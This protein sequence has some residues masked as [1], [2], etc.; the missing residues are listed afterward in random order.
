MDDTLGL[1][2][3]FDLDHVSAAAYVHTLQRGYFSADA[4]AVDLG[5]SHTDVDRAQ[6][7]LL[8]L[9]LLRPLPADPGRLAP[10]SPNVAVAELVS[11]VERLILRHQEVVD[12]IR[13]QFLALMPTYFEIRRMR[14]QGEA[15]DVV[16]GVDQVRAL[17]RDAAQRC[18][19]EVMTMQP[20][21]ARNPATLS[22]ALPRDL[23]MLA[24]GVRMRVLYQHTAR[25]HLPTQ[26]Y[27][28]AITDAGAE[29]RTTDE[30]VERLIIFDR[31]TAFLPERPQS[32]RVRGAAIV[33]EP[34]IVG[35]LCG[36]FEHTWNSAVPF[37][38][39][40]LPG[41]QT[42]SEDLKQAIVRMLARGE[43]DDVIARR[44]GVS[45]RTC[46]RHIAKIMQDLDATGRF[47]AGVIAARLGMVDLVET[48]K[49]DD[50]EKPDETDSSDE[51]D[52]QDEVDLLD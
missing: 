49:P 21:G 12:R 13:A 31:E 4:I 25:P 6:Q 7:V 35:F 18:T 45:V 17:L 14:N 1:L 15:V 5:L 51:S 39:D 34:A 24:N 19:G 48:E 33:R 3:G 27:V 44:L 2:P 32:G 40:G 26:S 36:V 11:P 28:R 50:G 38:R 52:E 20:G 29:V 23:A 43:K 9:R 41:Y 10:V 30:L 47:Q 37:L 46:R 22:D 8:G 16:N 42:V